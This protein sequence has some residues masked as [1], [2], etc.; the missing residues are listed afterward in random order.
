[1]MK[2][3]EEHKKL[4]I[5]VV[6]GI[7]S[8]SVIGMG[9]LI[10]N[11]KNIANS[12]ATSGCFCNDQ[13]KCYPDGCTRK[14]IK[15]DGT[16][17]YGRC[18]QAG[19]NAPYGQAYDTNSVEANRYFCI[20]QPPCCAE[21]FRRN[22]PEACCWPEKGYC[23]PN[24]YCTGEMKANNNCGWYWDFYDGATQNGYGCMKG[25]SPSTMQPVFGLPAVAGGSQPTNTPNPQPTST[26]A[27]TNTPV[28]T[29]TSVP[30][31]PTHTTAPSQP[32]NTPPPTNTPF[33]NAPIPTNQQPT[34][35]ANIEPS[36]NP[37]PTNPSLPTNTPYTFPTIEIKS[38]KEL[39]REVINP[40][41]IQNLESSTE[42]V[43]NAPKEGL[44]TIKRADQKLERTAHSWIEKVRAFIGNLLN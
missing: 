6:F 40:E 14:P 2:L 17:D 8:F 24:A 7:I 9:T 13:D 44:N 21:M 16:I 23:Y 32:T 35:V 34:E 10:Q 43:F 12:E 29:N 27:L 3:H 18:A 42:K 26:P 41:S 1:M 4:I 28:P 36:Y 20:Q 5:V 19:G 25:D 37:Q 22:D 38:P 30:P 15:S 31:N 33:P 11:R 39:A